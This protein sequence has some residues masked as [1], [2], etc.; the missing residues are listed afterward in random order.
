M[1]FSGGVALYVAFVFWEIRA[2]AYLESRKVR[3]RCHFLLK[4]IAEGEGPLSSIP[5]LRITVF[6]PDRQDGEP[7]LVPLVRYQREAPHDY[8]VKTRVRWRTDSSKNIK[9][10]W[11]NPKQL[12]SF[13][14]DRSKVKHK[15]GFR[16]IFQAEFGLTER[17]AKRLSDHTLME[18]QTIADIAIKVPYSPNPVALV[19]FSSTAPQ[20]FAGLSKDAVGELAAYLEMLAAML[21][22][23]D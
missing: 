19:S 16:G 12:Q 13:T 18:V 15:D 6:M 20:A 4:R 17:D 23:A 5:C 3:K 14:I 10:A 1:D 9:E 8:S 21:A 11:H 2:I 22:P 7:D